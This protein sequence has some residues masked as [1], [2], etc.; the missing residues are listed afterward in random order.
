MSRTTT[1]LKEFARLESG[2]LWRSGP[3][4][5][6]R[7]VIVTFGEATL[8]IADGAG[9]PQT[10]W[11]LAAVRRLNPGV[12][13][14]IFTAD[15]EGAETLEL[16]DDII[17]DAMEKVRK[18]VKRRRARPGRLRGLISLTVLAGLIAGGV[19]W[20]PEALI[21]QAQAVVPHVKRAE[22]GETLLG[23]IERVAG[24][25]CSSPLGTR[26]L[27]KLHRRALG[28]QVGG[29]IAVVPSGPELSIYLPGGLIV[30]NRDLIEDTQDPA[31]VGGHIIAAAAQVQQ[32][33]PLAALL[34]HSG[35]S[36]TFALLTTGDLPPESLRSYAESLVAE[37]APQADP[38]SHAATLRRG[39]AAQHTLCLFH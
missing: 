29:R 35:I 22:I 18:T 14:A 32:Q 24:Q 39:T 2:G 38:G 37:A 19:F 4:A 13:P 33:D 31:V 7:D 28:A 17:I 1:A 27:D 21:G 30:M 23:H 12:R 26:A 25:T 36:S 16:S 9:R 34:R 5:Q 15:G 11:S 8:T 10:H 6:R 20:L 3:E